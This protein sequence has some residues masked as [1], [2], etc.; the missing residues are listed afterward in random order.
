MFWQVEAKPLHPPKAME[1]KLGEKTLP[2][3]DG[4]L[5]FLQS[6]QGAPT[7]TAWEERE[8]GKEE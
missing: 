8:G 3:K 7:F 1:E 4:R 5:Q 6:L 2:A